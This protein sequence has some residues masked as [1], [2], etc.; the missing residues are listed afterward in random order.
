MTASKINTYTHIPLNATAPAIYDKSQKYRFFIRLQWVNIL[1]DLFALNVCLLLWQAFTEKETVKALSLNPD[2]WLMLSIS[3]IIWLLISSYNNIYQWQEI[4]SIKR[5]LKILSISLLA[6]LT[7]LTS[8]YTYGFPN[9]Y[10]D[11]LLPAILSFST[12]IIGLKIIY[13]LFIRQHAPPL[14]YV[15]VGGNMEDVRTIKSILKSTFGS[16][17]ECIRHFK[18]VRKRSNQHRVDALQLKYF[19]KRKAFD[20]LY[21]FDSNLTKEE[22]NATK[23][24][25]QSYFID[26]ELVPNII[27]THD[28]KIRLVN[29]GG[30]H[31]LTSREEPLQ[32]WYN[33][34]I[35]R[36]FDLVFSL[37]IIIFV[38]SWLIP[39]IAFFIKRES[40][41]PVFFIQERT[42]F[43]NKSFKILKFR[44]MCVNEECNQLQATKND[45]RLTK[46]GAFMRKFNIDELPQFI[47]VLIGDMSIVGPRPHMLKHTR[48]YTNLIENYLTRHRSKPGITGLAQINGYRGPTDTL[49]KMKKRIEYDAQYLK[50]WTFIL[51][52]YCVVFTV[53][54]MFKREENA[55]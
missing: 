49:F 29:Q 46:M 18:L 9:S 28:A 6:Y 5:R 47:N 2:V 41:G 44:S 50:N 1:T 3:T 20:K 37:L 32:K 7:V 21:Y 45:Y 14:K 42:G 33:A 8:V 26:F 10:S 43:W 53:I 16:K 25:C 38:L 40:E 11:F 24:L 30:L 4:V 17:N 34:F 48:E 52:L 39:L 19:I 13:I 31:I 15:V 12:L 54:N 22:I 23:E 35:K 55:L 27:E 36:T 51:D